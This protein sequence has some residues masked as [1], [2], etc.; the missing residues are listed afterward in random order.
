MERPDGAMTLE[1]QEGY[2]WKRGS[3]SPQDDRFMD[4]LLAELSTRRE[5]G[6]YHFGAGGAAL[7]LHGLHADVDAT[8]KGAPVLRK[9]VLK[10]ALRPSSEEDAARVKYLRLTYV[11]N[12]RGKL[13][14]QLQSMD[15]FVAAEA[16]EVLG[17]NH[18]DLSRHDEEPRS[19][20]I[21][22]ALQVFE[23]SVLAVAVFVP[24]GRLL[25]TGSSDL[26]SWIARLAD[27]GEAVY[28]LSLLSLVNAA[29][30]YRLI[31]R[32]TNAGFRRDAGRERRERF[33]SAAD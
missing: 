28:L 9:V 20:L 7:D 23:S 33:D 13:R 1:N 15:A 18:A 19:S 22:H 31:K 17:T 14:G 27:S 26:S 8:R 30:V 5:P 29:I 25:G 11:V 12:R 21:L 32:P 4:E 6:H 2:E 10:L 16:G 24:A 3:L